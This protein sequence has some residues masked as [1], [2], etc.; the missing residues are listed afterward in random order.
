MKNPKDPRHAARMI[1]L[2][3]L[4][5]KDFRVSES[6]TTEEIEVDEFQMIDEI[7]DFNEEL[8]QQIV[9]GVGEKQDE[10]DKYIKDFAPQ[11]PIEQIKKVDLQILRMA[12]FEGFVGKITPPKVAIDEAIELAKEFGGS[13]S[14]KFVNGVLGALYEKYKATEEK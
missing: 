4:F 9:E 11:W 3:Q 8:R 2:Q 7:E 13:A 10:I 12:I 14:D 1:A 6:V 5:L